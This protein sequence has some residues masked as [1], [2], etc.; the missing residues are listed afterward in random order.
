VRRHESKSTHREDGRRLLKT[1]RKIQ[2]TYSGGETAVRKSAKVFAVFLLLG[3]AAI[4]FGGGIILS[5]IG[6]FKTT[7]GDPGGLKEMSL[8]MSMIVCGMVPFWM[9]RHY[10]LSSRSHGKEDKPTNENAI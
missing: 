2:E 4:C 5:A 8:G 3:I 7:S 9:A 1:K 6:R 10:F